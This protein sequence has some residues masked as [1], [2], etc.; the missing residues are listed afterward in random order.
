MHSSG[1][2]DTL[3]SYLAKLRDG[4]YDYRSVE[5]PVERVVVNG[6][7]AMVFGRMR[8]DITAGGV[9]KRLDNRSLSVWV[10]EESGWLFFAYHP[11]PVK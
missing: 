3:E 2:A 10:R 6:E 7:V 4:F 11:T 1:E 8:A 9:E 5:H